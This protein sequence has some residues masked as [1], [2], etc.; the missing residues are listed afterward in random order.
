MTFGLWNYKDKDW[1]IRPI[2]HSVAMFAR[3]VK[4][5]QKAFKV[6]STH[7]RRIIAARV[8]DTVFWL[9]MTEKATEV[10]V[11]NFD[12]HEIIAMTEDTVQ[13][14]RSCGKTLEVVNGTL[15]VPARSFG[16]IKGAK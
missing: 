4:A 1:S 6:N 16:Y 8:E 15:T 9:N 11:N 13:G 5:G 12:I 7:P 10:Q 14:D 3:H 2:Y